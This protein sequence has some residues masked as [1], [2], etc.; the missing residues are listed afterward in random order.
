MLV[1]HFDL[2]QKAEKRWSVSKVLWT[3]VM[4]VLREENVL[5]DEH[6]ISVEIY[7]WKISSIPSSKTQK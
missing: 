7:F 2:S 3:C 6:K 5:V 4:Q 1:L